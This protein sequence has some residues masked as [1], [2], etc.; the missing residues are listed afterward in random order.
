MIGVRAGTFFGLSSCL[1]AVDGFK[2]IS[3]WLQAG[4]QR[5]MA[6]DQTIDVLT[7]AA[8]QPPLED[9]IS[10]APGDKNS[11]EQADGP[12]ASGAAGQGPVEENSEQAARKTDAEQADGSTEQRGSSPSEQMASSEQGGAPPS[13]QAAVAPGVAA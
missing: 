7:G 11:S 1:R 6:L 2:M 4:A 10:Q 12:L 8:G 13:E 9:A 5:S 3:G